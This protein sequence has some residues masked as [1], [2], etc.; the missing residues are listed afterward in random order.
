MACTTASVLGT[1]HQG[2]MAG[3][4]VPAM[5]ALALIHCWIDAAGSYRPTNVATTCSY[6][7]HNYY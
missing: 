1:T 7:C 6:Y 5:V 4:H 2:A 3:H